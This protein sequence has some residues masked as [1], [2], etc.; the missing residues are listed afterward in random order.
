[1]ER[2]CAQVDLEAIAHNASLLRDRLCASALLCAVVKAEGYGHGALQAARAALGGGARWLAVATAQEAAQLREGGLS[3]VR[4]LV[5]GALCEQELQLALRASADV[6]IWRS[7][8][9]EALARAGGGRVHLKL[10]T[11]MGR[12]GS[13]DPA[14]IIALAKRAAELPG[15]EVAGV[16]TH[17]ATADE[18]DDDGYFEGQLSAFRDLAGIVKALAPHAL[19]HAANSAA[20]LRDRQAHLDMARCGIAIYGMDPFGEDAPARGLRPALT[21]RSYLAEV[22]LLRAGEYATYGRRYRAPIDTFIGVVPIGYADGFRRA[23]SGRG[24]VLIEG[25]RYAQVGTVSMDNITIAL[26]SDRDCLALR[27]KEAVIIG[28]QGSE[29]ISAEE[30]AKRM[31]TINYEVTCAIGARVPRRYV[32]G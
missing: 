2:V 20:L 19:A 9:L 21:L 17:F 3:E 4:I 12:L 5:M 26:G 13:R 25:R 24:E 7:E 6:V 1:V 10:D 29:R 22:K 32:G 31:E 14:E 30:V 18:L 23:L 15:V 28:A 16:M 11:G 27:G 8:A